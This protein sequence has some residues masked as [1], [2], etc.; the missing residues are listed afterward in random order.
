MSW[1]GNKVKFKEGTSNTLSKVMP[2]LRCNDPVDQS[3]LYISWEVD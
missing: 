3:L 1:C 2:S